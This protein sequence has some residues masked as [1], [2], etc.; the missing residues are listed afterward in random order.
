MW[1]CLE[2]SK[3]Y[4]EFCEW[5]SKKELDPDLPTPR[6]FEFQGVTDL[7]PVSF[8]FLRDYFPIDSFT[9]D[10]WWD[11]HLK[12]KLKDEA[13]K[14]HSQMVTQ[15][16]D[17]I[18]KDIENCI[19]SFKH[20][21]K[22]HPTLSEFKKDFLRSIRKDWLEPSLILKIRIRKGSN[23]ELTKKCKE[24]ISEKRK[25]EIKPP[26]R[27]RPEE[28]RRYLKIYELKQQGLKMRDIIKEA[29]KPAQRENSRDPDVVRAFNRDFQKAKELIRNAELSK[30]PV[31]EAPSKKDK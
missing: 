6:K 22:R 25:E 17:E 21:K 19:S 14:R 3:D 23:Q 8:D 29:G 28:I 7:R 15:Y 9:F 12:K 10:E 20:R 2:R 24:L 5:S 1:E 13:N 18:G 31:Y 11:N 4:T 26:G 16:I 27:I 30:F